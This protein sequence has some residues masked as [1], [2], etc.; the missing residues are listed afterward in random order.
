ERDARRDAENS[1]LH[2]RT[3]A[4]TIPQQ[5]WT[6]TADGALDFVNERAV[7]YFGRPAAQVIGDGWQT[8]VHPDD[9]PGV[10]ERWGRSLQTGKGYEVEFRLRRRDG[11]YRWHL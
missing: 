7:E 10:M 6:A 9:L 3:L 4:A 2:Y 8:V 1:E 11:I 5:V